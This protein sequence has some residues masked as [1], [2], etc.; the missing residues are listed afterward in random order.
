MERE[1]KEYL[2]GFAGEDVTADNEK[3]LIDG[4][5]YYFTRLG[6]LGNEKQIEEIDGIMKARV[7]SGSISIL[8]PDIFSMFRGKERTQVK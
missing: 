4:W 5:N 2:L 7:Q 6:I 3:P 1:V 8:A